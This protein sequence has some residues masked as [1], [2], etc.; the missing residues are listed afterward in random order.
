[1]HQFQ[2]ELWGC[3][4]ALLIDFTRI[5]GKKRV[6]LRDNILIDSIT[7]HTGGQKGIVGRMGLPKHGLLIRRVGRGIKPQDAHSHH[8][9]AALNHKMYMVTIQRLP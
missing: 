8:P 5:D 1:M 7:Q 4:K 3:L 6:A 2:L 9:E